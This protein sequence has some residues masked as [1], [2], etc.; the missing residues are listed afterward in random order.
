MCRAFYKEPI[1]CFGEQFKKSHENVK[2]II[3]QS[4]VSNLDQKRYSKFSYY[5]TGLGAGYSTNDAIDSFF[6][7]V[8]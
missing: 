5:F 7:R 6:S 1:A 8:L 4:L 3:F 2:S